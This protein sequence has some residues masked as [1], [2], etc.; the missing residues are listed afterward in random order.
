MV[1]ATQSRLGNELDIAASINICRI[2][3]EHAQLLI[4]FF[5]KIAE[6]GDDEYFHPHPF[7]A[8]FAYRIAEYRGGD[9]YYI[10]VDQQQIAGYGMLRGWD[11]GYEVPSLGIIIHPNFR[12]KRLGRHLMVFLHQQARR[13]QA[14]QLRLKVYADNL[15]A[16]DLYKTLGYEFQKI[17]TGQL[18]GIV[19]L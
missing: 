16:I 6:S 15:R 1:D 10:M 7:T 8:E 12:G 13:C 19:D 17:E 2:R 4:E 3:P 18:M 9:L 5:H 14:K 11:D